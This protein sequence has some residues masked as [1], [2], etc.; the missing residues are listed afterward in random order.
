MPE[1]A[2]DDVELNVF[3]QFYLTAFWALNSER[4]YESGQIPWSSVELYC[5]KL[6][7]NT[8]LSNILSRIINVLDNE[9]LTL[10]ADSKS[11]KNEPSKVK[12]PK[13]RK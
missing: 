8:N 7:L 3:E 2:Q 6:E 4:K 10:L 11:K 13:G 9:Y 5:E 12:A 1:W